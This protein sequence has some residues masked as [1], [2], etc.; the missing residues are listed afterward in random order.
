ML[1]L[2]DKKLKTLWEDINFELLV[3]KDNKIDTPL[4]QHK[5]NKLKQSFRF[6]NNLQYN[7][8]KLNW[9]ECTETKTTKKKTKIT[10]FVT[11]THLMVNKENV[12][13]LSNYARQRWNIELD[14]FDIQK[15][16]GY[17]L[18][19]KYSRCSL[20]ARQNY[21][22]CLQ[23]AHI[24]NQLA[25]KVKSFINQFHNKESDKLLWE[26]MIAFIMLCEIENEKVEQIYQSNCQLRY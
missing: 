11:I 12:C 5:E 7:N 17:G 1:T 8:F 4:W 19:H 3:A 16:H 13:R 18:K 9:I 15:N 2:K 26:C 20:R 25:M 14:G 10:R 23:I 21:Y 24:I 6:L 22:Q